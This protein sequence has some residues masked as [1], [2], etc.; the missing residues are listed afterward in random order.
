MIL[1]A[2]KAVKITTTDH[3]LMIVRDINFQM[4]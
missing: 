2:A 3:S 1:K 4:S